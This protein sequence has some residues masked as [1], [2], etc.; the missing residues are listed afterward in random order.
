MLQDRKTYGELQQY[1]IDHFLEPVYREWLG[2]AVLAGRVDIPD[3]TDDPD[4]YQEAVWIPPGW[5]WID[6]LKEASA[7]AKALET[8]QTT[9]QKICAARGEDW[10]EL[11]EQRAREIAWQNDLTKED[12]NGNNDPAGS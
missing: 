9:L 6:P 12:S 1:L 4:G 7:N 2:W 3:Y 11:M 8:G 5:E 10:R